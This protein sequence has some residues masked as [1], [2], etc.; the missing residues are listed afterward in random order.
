M[1]QYIERYS[2]LSVR[3]WQSE[4]GDIVED[5]DKGEIKDENLRL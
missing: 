5:S 4:C 3:V 1:L 2:S